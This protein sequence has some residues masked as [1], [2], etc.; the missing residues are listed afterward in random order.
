MGGTIIS[1][2]LGNEM[3]SR[4]LVCGKLIFESRTLRPMK[5]DAIY[6]VL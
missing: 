2:E 5:N 6:V 3:M 4:A 1:V